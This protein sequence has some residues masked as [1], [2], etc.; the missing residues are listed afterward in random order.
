MHFELLAN[1]PEH[2]ETVAGWLCSEWGDSTPRSR[3][4]LANALRARMS[5]SS[6]PMHLLAF[7]GVAVVGFVALKLHEMDSYPD[8]KHWLGSLYVPVTK[9]GCGI[10]G[11]LIE[12]VILRSRAQGVTL[13]SLQTERLDGGLYRRYGWEDVERTYSRGDE[14]LVMERKIEH[15]AQQ[16]APRYGA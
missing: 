10:G 4:Q 16:D 12:E 2:A 11:A 15:E 6:L 1:F 7:D 8:R 13:L 3:D 14:V 9:R 5:L